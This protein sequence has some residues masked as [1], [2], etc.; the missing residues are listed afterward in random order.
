[1]I[2]SNS[3]KWFCEGSVPGE[4]SGNMNVCFSIEKKVFEGK[5]LYQ[6]ALIFDNAVY[7]R[8]FILDGIV[9]LSSKDEFIYHEM[10][11][12]PVMLSHKKPENIL[13]IGGG[14][15][16]VLRE[17]LK[18]PV[19]KVDLVELDKQ[20]VDI[21][22]KYLPFLKSKESFADKRVSVF[23]EDGKD[24]IEKTK[25]KYDIVIIDCTNPEPG[26]NSSTLYSEIFY[27]NISKSLGKD[28]II[29]TLGSSFLDFE[30]I[31]KPFSLRMKKAF[32]FVSF[33]RFTMPSYHCGEY[34]FLMGSKTINLK[35]PDFKD[36]EKRFKSLK[37]KHSFKY[38]S[39]EIHKA[40]LLLPEMWK[41]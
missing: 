6:K 22:K 28:G 3:K 2:T 8:V 1:M 26:N 40:S 41:I 31:S 30:K 27:K 39:P 7:G 35:S 5:T 13:V 19:K 21:S 4:R 15:G 24:F 10:M 37:K 32:L 18:Y 12:H 25:E 14:D 17:I 23:F 20:V 38:Y 16:G 33:L 34:S 9:E 11:V 36:I 29:I